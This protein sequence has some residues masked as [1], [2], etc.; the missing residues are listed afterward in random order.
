M[1]TEKG[2]ER[3]RRYNHSESAASVPVSIG[4]AKR[5]GMSLAVWLLTRKWRISASVAESSD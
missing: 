4:V 1:T 3:H 5:V 2:G